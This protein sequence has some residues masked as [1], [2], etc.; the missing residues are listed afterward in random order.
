MSNALDH[1]EIHLSKIPWTI[2]AIPINARPM[3]NKVTKNPIV[4]IGKDITTIANPIVN[5]PSIILLILDDCHIRQEANR[6][7]FYSYYK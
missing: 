5:A 7:S 4:N 6:Y 1:F 3:S 2:L